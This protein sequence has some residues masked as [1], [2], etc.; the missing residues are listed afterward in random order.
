MVCLTLAITAHFRARCVCIHENIAVSLAS[1]TGMFPHRRKSNTNEKIIGCAIEV[2]KLSAQTM[3]SV[4]RECMVVEM[5]N[6]GLRFEGERL[7]KLTYKGAPINS[8]CGGFTCEG[9][10]VVG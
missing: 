10:V 7:I 6:A 2:I 9:I 5:T 8:K 3:E 1:Q 4:Y